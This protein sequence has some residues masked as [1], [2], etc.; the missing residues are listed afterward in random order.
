MRPACPPLTYACKFLNFSISRSELDLA[1]RAAIREIEGE[2]LKDL[3]VYTQPGS[4]RYQAMEEII[5]KKLNLTSLKYQRMEDLVAAIGLPKDR[6]CT[7]CWDGAEL[8]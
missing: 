7:Y 3:S 2:N 5:R 8:R 6:L 1:A 4:G